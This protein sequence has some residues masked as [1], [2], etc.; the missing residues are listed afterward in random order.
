M[1]EDHEPQEVLSEEPSLFTVNAHCDKK[2]QRKSL[3]S[4]PSQ[5]V[6]MMRVVARKSFPGK[7]VF[8]RNLLKFLVQNLN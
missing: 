5:I 8:M 2:Q 6:D 7:R 4:P 1:R 3:R